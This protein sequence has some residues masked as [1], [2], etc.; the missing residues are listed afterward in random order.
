MQ[1]GDL[2]SLLFL[3]EENW[4]K[5]GDNLRI[6][7]WTYNADTWMLCDLGTDKETDIFCLH[8]ICKNSQIVCETV[9][10]LPS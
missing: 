9:R 7:K 1:H 2:M 8:A 4:F 5:N 6:Y 10:I 3:E